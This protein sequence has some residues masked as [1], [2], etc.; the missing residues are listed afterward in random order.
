MHRV[1]PLRPARLALLAVALAACAAPRTAAPPPAPAAAPRPIAK[2]FLWEV[3]RPGQPDRPLYLTGSMHLARPGA[4]AL[5]PSFE[6]ALA[7]ADALVVE[8]DVTKAGG[9]AEAVR[10]VQSLGLY[11][12]PR[13]LSAALDPETRA[14]LSVAL[15]RHGLTGAAVEP[16]RPWVVGM[17]LEVLEA[18]RIGLEPKQGLEWLL[19]ERVRGRKEVAELETEEGQVRALAGIPEPVQVT[20]L[21]QILQQ[22]PRLAELTD[23][24][25]AAW[26]GGDLAVVERIALE[27]A[28]DPATA[29]ALEAIL[30]ARNRTMADA[31]APLVGGP[32]VHLVVIGAA[33]LVGDRGL[34]A[35][36]SARG[37][38]VRQLPRE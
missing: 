4:F 8:I 27:G 22:E 29:A 19:L 38:Q 12:P 5:P 34:L 17:M 15:A 11:R 10:L 26:R 6:A 35:L 30:F 13:T 25:A 1:R 21:R 36:L 18:K 3:T 31:I 16:L 20:M 32:K 9:Q 28:D 7:R 2:A 14:L 37:L 24:M 33:H 23:E